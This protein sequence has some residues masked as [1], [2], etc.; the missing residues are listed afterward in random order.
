MKPNIEKPNNFGKKLDLKLLP[1][2]Q[3]WMSKKNKSQLIKV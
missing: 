3:T 2:L 1:E